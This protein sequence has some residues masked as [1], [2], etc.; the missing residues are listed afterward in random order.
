MTE[1]LSIDAPRPKHSTG[2]KTPE[3]KRRCALN[4]YRHGLT[5]QLVIITPEEQIAYDQ[6]SQINLESMAP[7][8]AYE[9]SL[10]PRRFHSSTQ[11]IADD[12][13]RL[14]RARSIESGIFA[15]GFQAPAADATG[16]PQVDD[17]FAQ[18]RTWLNDSRN[19]QLLTIYEQRIQRSVDKNLAQLETLQAKRQATAMEDMRQG[20]AVRARG[21]FHRRPAAQGV[22]FFNSRSRPRADP[23]NPSP[24]RH[25]QLV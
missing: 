4:A 9:R 3:G 20:Q 8:N 21:I 5:G 6:H 11:S 1:P 14:T 24:R 25:A 19:L 17:A 16:V 13:W 18:A 10:A 22:C 15:L 23:R 12:R 2:P 7:A